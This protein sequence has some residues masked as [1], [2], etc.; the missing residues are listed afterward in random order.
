MS[1]KNIIFDLGGVILNIDFQRTCDAFRKFGIDFSSIYSQ[2]NQDALFDKFEIGMI[3]ANDF[4]NAIKMQLKLKI[5]DDEFDEAWNAMLLDLP[6]E[7]LNFIAALRKTHRLFLF[8]NTNEIHLETVF[9]ICQREHGIGSL[10]PYF[11]KEYYSCRFGKR[12]PNPDAFKIIL[13]ENQL[14][15]NETLFVDDTLQH[16][17]G[18]QLA[19]LHAIHLAPGKTIFDVKAQL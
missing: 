9:R 4:R 6:K 10:A 3:T 8:S 5:S 15:A 16:V 11:D 18:A 17:N 7:R 2:N 13:N 14:K 1:F 12:K 19:G